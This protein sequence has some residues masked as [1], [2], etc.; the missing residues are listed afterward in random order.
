MPHPQYNVHGEENKKSPTLNDDDL[1]SFGKH[2]NL[3]MQDVPASYL[4][5]L[6]DEGC[7]NIEVKNYIWNSRNA[8]NEELGHRV[9][10]HYK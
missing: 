3:Q 5:W 4:A 7:S 1:M 2:K 9:I 10:T 6:W 8:I